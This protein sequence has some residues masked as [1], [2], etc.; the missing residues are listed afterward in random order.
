LS[1]HPNLPFGHNTLKLRAVFIPDGAQVSMADINQ[2]VGRDPVLIPAVLVPPGGALP[3]YPYEPIGAAI[4]IRDSNDQ[5]RSTRASSRWAGTQNDPAVPDKP[6]PRR[7]HGSRSPMAPATGPWS[8][9]SGLADSDQAR[10]RRG[11]RSTQGNFST[12]VPTPQIDASHDAIDVAVR[13]LNV[14]PATWGHPNMTSWAGAAIPPGTAPLQFPATLISVATADPVGR[15]DTR[16]SELVSE[17]AE[18]RQPR[19]VDATSSPS[20][21]GV[22]VI[23]PDGSTVPDTTLPPVD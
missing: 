16:P 12:A 15:S 7:L 9:G 10:P 2:V 14:R 13:A 6:M 11:V 20:D 17:A 5:E 4:F 3:G 22:A 19:T 8:M 23:L 18:E 21:P 1:D